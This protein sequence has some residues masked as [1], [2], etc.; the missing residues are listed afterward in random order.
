MT[1]CEKHCCSK[2]DNEALP[3]VET[4]EE[5]WAFVRS[6]TG[7]GFKK[8]DEIVL[9]EAS[10]TEEKKHDALDYS[11]FE[12]VIHEIDKEEEEKRPPEQRLMESIQQQ[13]AGDPK[14]ALD[15]L[16]GNIPAETV[17][18]T[19]DGK[20]ADDTSSYFVSKEALAAVGGCAHDRSKERALYNRPTQEKL[21]MARRFRM[22]GNVAFKEK[23]FKRASVNYQKALLYYDYTFPETEE[24]EKSFNENKL[25]AH[26][27]L[28]A[29]KLN[30][31]EYREC[32]SQCYQATRM[33]AHCLKAFYR[34]AQAHLALDEFD[35]VD[36]VLNEVKSFPNIEK[37]E[38]A[39][40]FKALQALCVTK[41]RQHAKAMPQ[42]FKKMFEEL[43]PHH[44]EASNA[45][46]ASKGLTGQNVASEGGEGSAVGDKDVEAMQ[47][48][49]EVQTEMET[50]DHSRESVEATMPE[51][52]K[53]IEASKGTQFTPSLTPEDVTE[54]KEPECDHY[55]PVPGGYEAGGDD[56]GASTEIKE[57][58]CEGEVAT[59][60]TERMQV[61]KSEANSDGECTA[62]SQEIDQSTPESK[63]EEIKQS[64]A[65]PTT[66]ESGKIEVTPK[67]CERK[68][69]AT[70]AT[71]PPEPSHHTL[72]DSS[73]E[74][75]EA[76]L[77]EIQ[78]TG[79]HDSGSMDDE[80][81]ISASEDNR[82][83]VSQAPAPQTFDLR[84]EDEPTGRGDASPTDQ[85]AAAPHQYFTISSNSGNKQNSAHSGWWY[86][87]PTH[88]FA[89]PSASSD[90]EIELTP[91]TRRL[92]GVSFFVGAVVTA[93][94]SSFLVRWHLPPAELETPSQ[95]KLRYIS[96]Y[97]TPV[98]VVLSGALACSFIR[99]L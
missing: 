27:N 32:I 36:A 81:S 47:P 86:D 73:E 49:K 98:T 44:G 46:C 68:V 70:A 65:E 24:E 57:T 22:E 62:G 89:V 3:K 58:G 59:P 92:M 38:L 77:P 75:S 67:E 55:A 10:F 69:S 63:T 61:A 5:A 41:K 48:E 84:T 93:S 87:S 99:F 85:P 45:E 29:A 6:V 7:Y 31:G 2:T 15:L 95:Q 72:S 23:N 51:N 35:E 50:R 74:K 43:S 25:A 66:E 94:V 19:D 53:D 97:L 9:D 33:D 54:A 16:A 52:V 56:Q 4:S 82:L 78:T 96:L 20:D 14:A 90:N 21:R 76:P 17:P 40:S 80:A 26:L 8:E 79:P 11:R 30:L 39:S 64:G 91:I 83:K 34:K 18:E 1:T 28:A 88:S 13:T 71:L 60:E 37:D 42:V 12:A